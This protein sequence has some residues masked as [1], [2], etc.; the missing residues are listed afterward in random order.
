MPCLH[1]HAKI[2]WQI[3]APVAAT[4]SATFSAWQRRGNKKS[5]TIQ[6]KRNRENYEKH[7][8]V[9][10]HRQNCR[11]WRSYEKTDVTIKFYAKNYPLRLIFKSVRLKMF[12]NRFL[13]FSDRPWQKN[14]CFMTFYVNKYLKDKV[15]KML[16]GF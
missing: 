13:A 5:A 6:K 11:F 12:E 3:A 9:D 10:R 4:A 1:C 7:Q 16:H 14:K 2:K 15:S 8:K